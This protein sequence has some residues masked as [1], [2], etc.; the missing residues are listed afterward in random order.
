M[1]MYNNTQTIVLGSVMGGRKE[2][3]F[4]DTL[5]RYHSQYHHCLCQEVDMDYIAM[6]IQVSLSVGL[7]PQTC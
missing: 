1:E 4:G 7:Y 3:E 6:S 2:E 5:T